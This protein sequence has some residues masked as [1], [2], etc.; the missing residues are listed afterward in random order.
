MPL[1][2]KVGLS[3]GDSCV[4]WGPSPLPKKEAEP[5]QI[6]AYVCCGQTAGWIKMPLGAEVV[7][8]P[9]RIVLDGNP[10]AAL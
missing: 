10:A 8:S 3:P 1:G 5:P 7:L 6:L 2:T 9:G 4:R